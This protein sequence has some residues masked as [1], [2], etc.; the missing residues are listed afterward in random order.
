MVLFLIITCTTLKIVVLI[1]NGRNG[2]LADHISERFGISS[3]YI[4]P[5]MN[6]S[7]IVH[8]QL[9]IELYSTDPAALN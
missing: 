3:K 9:Y 6:Y 4:A 7:Y 8:Q 5:S 1:T 2:A